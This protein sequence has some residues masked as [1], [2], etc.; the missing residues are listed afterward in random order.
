MTEPVAT[1]RPSTP[2]AR[3]GWLTAALGVLVV[4]AVVALC[5]AVR[6]ADADP[7]APD[8]ELSSAAARAGIAARAAT[9]AE[10]AITYR[11]VRADQD[12][13][14][15]ERLMTPRMR[16]KY[17]QSLPPAA[18]RPQQAEMNVAVRGTVASVS[19][20]DSCRSD[21]CAVGIVSATADR[22]RVLVFID[23]TATAKGSKDSVASPTWELLTLVKQD[24]TW[25]IDDLTA[26]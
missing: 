12:I 19:G 23:Q 6:H 26:S 15:A 1:P 8:G 24:G 9:L 16:Q 21:D 14:A 10:T 5:L 2:L 11:A 22:A 17:K 4:A 25:L 3:G 13:A 20:K 7:V 18:D